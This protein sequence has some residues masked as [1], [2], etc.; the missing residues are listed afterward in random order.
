M[1]KSAERAKE[2]R[3]QFTEGVS[4]LLEHMQDGNEYGSIL[5][6]NLKKGIDLMDDMVRGLK[7]IEAIRMRPC[8]AYVGN[9]VK[10]LPES[11]I[12]STDD[13]P[14]TEMVA[15]TNPEARKVDVF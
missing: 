10:P 7:E 2:R 5:P 3:Q 12:D 15:K 8:L 6:L 9:V 11:G 4:S 1:K 13:L 14:F